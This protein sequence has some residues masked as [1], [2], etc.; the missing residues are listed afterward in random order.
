MSDFD[1]T[2][3][4]NTLPDL[5]KQLTD[6]NEKIRL[7]DVLEKDADGGRVRAD[8]QANLDIEKARGML[9]ACIEADDE[10]TRG[11]MEV[12][13]K[14][15]VETIWKREQHLDSFDLERRLRADA[16]VNLD[17]EKKVHEITRE[18]RQQ[19]DH[20]SKL[21]E[22][23]LA[24]ANQ[25]QADIEAEQEGRLKLRKIFG[26]RDDETM[27]A[28]IERLATNGAE[29]PA[30]VHE[31]GWQWRPTDEDTAFAPP[32]GTIRVC[33]SCGCLVSGGPTACGRCVD[34]WESAQKPVTEVRSERREAAQILIEEIGA[35][36]PENVE[37]TARRAVEEI[38][39][40]RIVLNEGG[41]LR[42]G[43]EPH[44]VRRAVQAN[45]AVMD[46]LR[47]PDFWAEE[48]SRHDTVSM[49]DLEDRRTLAGYLSE[50]VKREGGGL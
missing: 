27:G 38:R 9:E 4:G 41:L 43:M 14:R 25:L 32:F 19:L 34:S 47:S 36:G 5:V 8:A 42:G 24:H 23:R 39:S 49:D 10:I 17:I 40:L 16:Q 15:L 35:Q 26:A 12:H 46:K 11:M 29:V 31:R 44:Q 3:M 1:Q 18:L 50:A 21:A 7:K 33:R 2:P 22:E 45:A 37:A 20:A 48:L 30:E 6:L 28:F 13:A